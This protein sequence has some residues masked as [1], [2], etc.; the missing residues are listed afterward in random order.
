M[1]ARVHERVCRTQFVFNYS[2]PRSMNLKDPCHEH[3]V[4]GTWT[5]TFVPVYNVCQMF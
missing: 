5:D 4:S 3:A 1:C 2:A